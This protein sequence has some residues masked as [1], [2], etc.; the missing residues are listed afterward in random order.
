MRRWQTVLAACLLALTAAIVLGCRWFGPHDLYE[1]DQPKTMAYTADILVH[2]RYALPRDMIYQP[3]TKPPMYNWID[4]AVVGASGVWNEWT[5]KFPSVL[6]VLATGGIVYAMA[7]RASHHYSGATVVGLLATGIW[8][9]FGSD[10]RHGS[11]LR[12]GYLA[13]PDMLLTMFCTAAWACF[14]VAA[15]RP[16]SRTAFRPAMAA[17]LCVA[18]AVLTKGPAAALPAVFGVVYATVRV[19]RPRPVPRAFARPSRWDPMISY[20]ALGRAWPV[21][22]LAIVAAAGFGWLNAAAGHDARHVADVILG[23]EVAGRLTQTPEG[24]RSPWYASL[25]WFVTK[26]WPWGAVAVVGLILVAWLPRV[27]RAAGPAALYLLIVLIGLSVP[28][29]K[30]MD[31]LLPAFAPASVLVALVIADVVRYRVLTAA[32]LVTAVATALVMAVGKHHAVDAAVPVG[33][34]VAAMICYVIE[35]RR[36]V[37]LG[38]LTVVP[39][40]LAVLL[41]RIHLRKSLEAANRWSDNAVAFVD[42]VRQ[43]VPTDAKLLVIVRGKHPL[44]TLLGR[45]QGSYLTPNDLA[46]AEYVILPTQPDLSAVV[47]SR[48]L[49]IGFDVVEQRELST[50]GLYRKV[51]LDRLIAY[52]KAC[53]EWTVTENPYHAPGT[54]FRDD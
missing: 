17:W 36:A 9:T 32:A 30:R 28:A 44:V 16:N 31:Y 52:Q 10:V 18:A 4:A 5:L 26:A 13:R 29:A 19:F 40:V 3:A 38:L 22:G 53:A 24:F 7:R 39:L 54:V 46:T 23:A 50:L 41:G 45:H 15:E 25:M 33:V 21:L 51:P 12:L 42:Q 47:T 1:K 20:F 37:P 43:T 27:R 14:T 8:F 2:G 48:P 6:G 49:P 34:V 11:V 35:R